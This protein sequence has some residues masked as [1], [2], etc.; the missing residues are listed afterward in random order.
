MVSDKKF[1]MEEM[2]WKEIEEA[3]EEGKDT[4]VL[5]MGSF[6]QHGPHMPMKTDT[7]ISDKLGV[8]IAERLDFALMGPTLSVGVSGHHMDFPGTVSLSSDVFMKL[9]EEHCKSFDEHGFEFIALVPFH[10]GNFAPAKTAAAEIAEE[11]KKSKILLV[12]DLERNTK[13][14]MESFKEAGMEYVE[15]AVHSGAT[16]TSVMLAID[17]D[18]VDEDRLEKGY[19]GKVDNSSLFTEGLKHFTDNGILGD[20][21]KASK[22]AGELILKNLSK[23]LAEQIDEKRSSLLMKSD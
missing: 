11:M 8:R 7:Y 9:I 6:E 3:K 23:D 19:E 2:S 1:K 16:E 12:A 15:K 13:I 18:L 10:G 21:R 22:E 14:M 20:A 4:V 5:M 17:E